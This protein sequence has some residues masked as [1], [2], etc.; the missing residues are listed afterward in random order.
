MRDAISTCVA[1]LQDAV[2]KREGSIESKFFFGR[3]NK[4]VIAVVTC[5]QQLGN[6]TAKAR[7]HYTFMYTDAA[8]DVGYQPIH[9]QRSEKGAAPKRTTIWNKGNIFKVTFSLSADTFFRTEAG[10]TAVTRKSS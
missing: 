4:I 3:V 5:R 10:V 2:P 1:I 6:K 7:H 9:R 8:F